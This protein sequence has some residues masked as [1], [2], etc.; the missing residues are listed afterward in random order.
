MP[1][2]ATL[3]AVSIGGVGG[4]VF[5]FSD[6][7]S[8]PPPR[9]RGGTASAAAQ[10]P[11]EV[12][13]VPDDEDEELQRAL[14]ASAEMATAN[15]AVVGGVAEPIEVESPSPIPQPLASAV[16][17]ESGGAT[18]PVQADASDGVAMAVD[19]GAEAKA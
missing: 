4:S 18:A 14:A 13:F 8:F 3:H 16:G 17:E 1:L 6:E 12:I 15:A 5:D 2:D 10:G 9:A 11:A 7:P 19:D